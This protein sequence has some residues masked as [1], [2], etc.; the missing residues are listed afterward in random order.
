[1]RIGVALSDA[2]T[3]YQLWSDSFDR[4]EDDLLTL[5]GEIA[6]DVSRALQV[7][8]LVRRGGRPL[9]WAAPQTPAP[10]TTTCKPS[11]SAVRTSY[12]LP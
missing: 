12:A 1:M 3:G 6:T 5:Q 2:L 10:S 9:L 8:L 4:N 7:T 11:S